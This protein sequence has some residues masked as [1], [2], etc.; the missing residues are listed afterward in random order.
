MTKP[1]LPDDRLA[2]SPTEVARLLGIG[3]TLVFELIHEGRLKSIRIGCR[4][5]ITKKQLED[6]LGGCEA[7]T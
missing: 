5:L 3:R 6:F 2:Y 7:C 4:R 1:V